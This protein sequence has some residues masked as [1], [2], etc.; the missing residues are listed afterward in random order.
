MGRYDASYGHVLRIGKGGQME[1][2]PLGNLRV[3][4]EVRRI[5]QVRVGGK[6]GFVFARN[7]REALLLEVQNLLD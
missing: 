4:G 7:N 3:D 2:F 1:V 6:T 5:R